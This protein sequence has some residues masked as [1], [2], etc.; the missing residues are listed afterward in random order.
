MKQIF[1]ILII[2]LISCADSKTTKQL[3]SE[4]TEILKEQAENQFPVLSKHSSSKEI[5][6]IMVTDKIGNTIPLSDILSND[7]NYVVS[8]MASWCAPCNVELNA[9][10]QVTDRWSTELN[11]EIIALSIEKPSDTHKLFAKAKM[12]NWTMRVFHDKMAYTAKELDVFDIPHT[13]LVNRQG[14]ITYKTEG[15]VP[16]IASTYEAEIE[17]LLK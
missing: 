4:G 16:N 10:S 8:L 6:R 5:V 11:T 3:A 2:I 1:S 13:F 15:F 9:L 17:K 7:K 12:H 14:E